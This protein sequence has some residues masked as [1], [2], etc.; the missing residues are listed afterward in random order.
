MTKILVVIEGGL[1][2]GVWSDD[3]DAEAVVIDYD[4]DEYM[5][6]NSDE[7]ASPAHREP[8]LPWDALAV[9]VVALVT[10]TFA[11]KETA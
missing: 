4:I 3:P 1:V 8:V 2:Q 9:D 6:D 5:D 11:D 10:D 7:L